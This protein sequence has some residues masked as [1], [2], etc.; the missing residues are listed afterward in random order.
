[1]QPSLKWSR[2]FEEWLAQFPCS[3]YEGK[4]PEYECQSCD[5]HKIIK[6]GIIGCSIF[7]DKRDGKGCLYHT[8]TTLLGKER[9]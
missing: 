4:F 6:G 8:K 7:P 5:H 1:M 2:E 9:S 3:A